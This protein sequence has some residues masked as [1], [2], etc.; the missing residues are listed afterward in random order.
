M[1]TGSFSSWTEAGDLGLTVL[2][3]FTPTFDYA[4]QTLYLDSVSDPY[5]APR[6]RSGLAFT[7]NEPGAIE[8]VQVRPDS[9]AARITSRVR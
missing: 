5:V 7:K 2:G 3:R 6:N 9:A 1:K 4:N 8:V